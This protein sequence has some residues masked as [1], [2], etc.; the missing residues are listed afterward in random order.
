MESWEF[1]QLFYVTWRE[2]MKN[3]EILAGIKSADMV[4]VGLGE[5]FNDEKK[6]RELPEYTRGR[7]L[8]QEAGYHWLQP[9]WN[10]YCLNKIGGDYIKS[11]LE[12]LAVLLEDKNYFVV[13]TS[14]NKM[15]AEI[16]WKKDRLVMPCGS[17][18][19]KQCVKGCAGIVDNVNEEDED[20]MNECFD[21]LYSGI[22]PQN[23]EMK[24]GN[25]PKCGKNMIFNNIFAES[26]NEA[27]YTEQWQMYTRWLQGTLNRKLIVLE[28]GVN[29]RFPSVIRWPFEKVVFFNNKAMLIR[30]NENLYQLTEELS[31]KGCG[32]PQNAIEWL[33]TLC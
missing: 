33:K 6:L 14:T 8:L 28:L 13:T 32:I 27:G 23:E 24:L 12:K 17:T 29:M 26:Y 9:A 11:V 10:E 20:F 7:E 18:L 16:P 3:E 1:S 4:L 25:C 19:K 2:I 22:F 21:S 15:I 31:G 5:E 30:V